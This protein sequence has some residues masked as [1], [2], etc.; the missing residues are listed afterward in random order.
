MIIFGSLMQKNLKKTEICSFSQNFDRELI[1]YSGMWTDTDMHF[2]AKVP[3][4]N[5]VRCPPRRGAQRP[6]K[7]SQFRTKKSTL[8]EFYE[9]QYGFSFWGLLNPPPPGTLRYLKDP[10]S[11]RQLA[12]MAFSHPILKYFILKRGRANVQSMELLVLMELMKLIL[13]VQ[14]FIHLLTKF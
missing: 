1:N 8:G 7:K 14:L 13:E 12:S 10:G 3:Q 11:P 2:F 4:C 5:L 9:P 6:S